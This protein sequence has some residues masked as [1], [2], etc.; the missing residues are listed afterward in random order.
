VLETVDLVSTVA[1]WQKLNVL[2]IGTEKKLSK[3]N[4]N[5]IKMQAISTLT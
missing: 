2:G 3:C 1:F 4:Q 5:A